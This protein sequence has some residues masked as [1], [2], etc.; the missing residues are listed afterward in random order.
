MAE[1][2]GVCPDNITFYHS[3]LSDHPW[4][5][6]D[7]LLHQDLTAQSLLCET[8]ARGSHESARED[9]L[10]G[11]IELSDGSE[12]SSTGSDFLH[13]YTIL[14]PILPYVN[15]IISPSEASAL[16][17]YF[18]NDHCLSSFDTR[19]PYNFA[20]IFRKGSI[21]RRKEP[22]P[23]SPAPLAAIF[24]VA[25]Q[26]CDE[27]VFR[28]RNCSRAEICDELLEIAVQLLGNAA[29]KLTSSRLQNSSDSVRVISN[30]GFLAATDSDTATWRSA[31]KSYHKWNRDHLNGNDDLDHVVAC[32][33]CAVVLSGS[34]RK[35]DCL[36]WFE[37]ARM[38]ALVLGLNR[39]KD[40]HLSVKHGATMTEQELIAREERKEERR[41]T[42]WLLYAMDRHLSLCYNVPLQLLD[43]KCQIYHPLEDEKWQYLEHHLSDVQS[44]QRPF[45]PPTTI[46]GPGFFGFFLPCMVVLGDI[47]ELHH[48]RLNPRYASFES[49]S[50]EEVVKSALQQLV[51][52][53]SCLHANSEALEV[54]EG[55]PGLRDK[56]RYFNRTGVA[57]AYST[58]LVNVLAIL[59][60]GEWDI[61]TMLNPDFSKRHGA[62]L[63]Q[64]C[65]Y[66]GLAS[67]AM[68]L[69]L[70]CDPELTFM[71]YLMGIYILQAGFA[72]L[73]VAERTDK[74]ASSAICTGLETFIRAHESCIATLD[75]KYQVSQRSIISE[76]CCLTYF[77][78]LILFS[79]F[80]GADQKV[81]KFPQSFTRHN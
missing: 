24:F 41:R 55:S 80:Y 45:G 4:V 81:E 33:L 44:P 8:N 73:T 40:D 17:D 47:V 62:R 38:M 37:K 61:I 23:T 21:L 1:T 6:P 26:T 22:R 3:L 19:S 43:T 10:T 52:S 42:W 36:M 50:F 28:N 20:T 49:Q 27:K 74:P 64:L 12:G 60:Y 67:Q 51:R 35:F 77:S 57:T 9:S 39:E 46:S 75:T 5:L 30:L 13:P 34:D 68:E 53:M 76:L 11:Y 54:A 48:L 7:S 59:T 78:L 58:F 32:I 29:P 16:L 69:I 70:E 2:V 72:V 25:A 18:F 65:H 66:T 71:P 31:S 63:A 14:R 15:H 79:L 56:H